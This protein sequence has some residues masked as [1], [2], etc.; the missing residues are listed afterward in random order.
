MDMC[1]KE[2][3]EMPCIYE[4]INEEEMVYLDGGSVALPMKKGYLNKTTCKNTAARLIKNKSVTGM[5]K[6]AIAEE[7]F[8]HAQLFFRAAGLNM[9][10]VDIGIINEIAEHAEVV[11]IDDGGDKWYRRVAYTALWY[12]NPSLSV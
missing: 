5:S 3:L 12:G 6:Q 4:I 10:G 1:L 2:N 11:N 9:A 8:A 7:I